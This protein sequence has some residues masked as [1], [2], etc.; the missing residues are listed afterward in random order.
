MLLCFGMYAKILVFRRPPKPNSQVESTSTFL[1]GYSLSML[2]VFKTVLTKT[3]SKNLHLPGLPNVPYNWSTC[4]IQYE[5]KVP[6]TGSING[7]YVGRNRPRGP[8][9]RT[10]DRQSP[11]RP[12]REGPPTLGRKNPESTKV[13]TNFVMG[14]HAGNFTERSSC[15]LLGSYEAALIGYLV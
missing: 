10:P 11:H 7:L 8:P 15:V 5:A 1:S 2:S 3:L 6:G 14:T 13:S 4:I 9:R 12:R